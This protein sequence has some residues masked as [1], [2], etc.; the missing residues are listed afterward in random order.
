MLERTHSSA[1]SKRALGFV[2][3]IG[4]YLVASSRTL[5]IPTTFANL[6]IRSKYVTP[7]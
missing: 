4:I 3:A 5:S 7:Y 2:Q 6:H 1:S